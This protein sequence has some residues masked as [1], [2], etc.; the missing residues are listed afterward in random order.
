MDSPR[1][2]HADL[3]DRHFLEKARRQITAAAPAFD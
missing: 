2:I 1:S 3:K